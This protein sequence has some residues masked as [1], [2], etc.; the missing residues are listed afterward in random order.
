MVTDGLAKSLDGLISR[1]ISRYDYD[2]IS[3]VYSGRQ[4]NYS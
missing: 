3:Q 2:I 4:D 1:D